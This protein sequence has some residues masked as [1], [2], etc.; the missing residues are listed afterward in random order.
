MKKAGELEEDRHI[1]E[2]FEKLYL[3]D[4]IK[5]L[6]TLL[7]LKFEGEDKLVCMNSKEFHDEI[8]GLIDRHEVWVDTKYKIVARKVKL[9]ALPLPLDHEEKVERASMQL[10]LRDPKMVGYEFSNMISDGLK[11]G[12]S[13]MKTF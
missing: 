3:G 7:N 8:E 11:V 5:G 6:N 13:D 4:F 2:M 12:S 10:N 9:V 1:L